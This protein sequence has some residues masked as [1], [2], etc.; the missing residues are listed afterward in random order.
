MTSSIVAGSTYLLAPP[1]PKSYTHNHILAS[2]LCHPISHPHLLLQLQRKDPDQRHASPQF[3]LVCR[4]SSRIP[5]RDRA[6]TK[7][8]SAKDG[9]H[10]P[11]EVAI[12]HSET[13]QKIAVIKY[14]DTLHAAQRRRYSINDD[15][16]IIAVISWNYAPGLRKDWTVHRYEQDRKSG[17]KN[18]GYEFRLWNGTY[19]RTKDGKDPYVRW[20]KKTVPAV[21]EQRS[22]SLMNPSS[23]RRRRSRS[24]SSVETTPRRHTMPST[25]T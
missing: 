17:G 15:N 21:S 9:D 5:N 3:D 13:G 4:K 10:R 7:S 2:L 19:L 24:V 1:P 6:T 14:A 11:R 20:T 12:Q 23:P 22:Q 8:I 16:S 18:V 25:P